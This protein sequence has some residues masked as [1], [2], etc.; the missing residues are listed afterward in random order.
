MQS[1]QYLALQAGA[2]F[3]LNFMS[4]WI[5]SNMIKYFLYLVGGFKTFSSFSKSTKSSSQLNVAMH[6]I[7]SANSWIVNICFQFSFC[8]P[9]DVAQPRFEMT[10]QT[11]NSSSKC[12]FVTTMSFFDTFT[13]HVLLHSNVSLFHFSQN[14][15]NKYPN[16]INFLIV[17]WFVTMK[18]RSFSNGWALQAKENTKE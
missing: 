1:K 9:S 17:R 15:I 2:H 10:H 13:N 12:E 4:K 14:D 5:S 7:F 11:R 16:C 18:N 6:L 8:S 3:S